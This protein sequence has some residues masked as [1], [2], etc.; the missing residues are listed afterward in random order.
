MILRC[1]GSD[2]FFI[3]KKA[4]QLV[5]Q[6]FLSRIF[7]HWKKS[8]FMKTTYLGHSCILME[9]MGKTILF[10]PFISGN[11]L[12]K[13]ID[14][15]SLNPDYILVSHAH[16][17]HVLDLERIAEKSKAK[18]VSNYEI[19]SYYNA[20]G[21]D[22]HPLN[23][24]GKASFDFG[25]VKYVNAVHSSVFPDGTYGGN[26]GGFVIW[27]EEACVY[28]AGD[29]ALTMDMKLIPMTCPAVD[30]AILPIGDNFTMDGEEALLAADFVQCDKIMACHYDTFGPIEVENKEELKKLFSDTGKTLLLPSVGESIKC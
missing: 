21:F 4:P 20:K 3:E 12:A 19:F 1:K 13:A 5:R 18:I 15:D 30:L 9:T 10:A 23:H 7:N 24:G 27:N 29:T 8:Y 6:R 22:G 17:D 16:M 25:T 28:F 11:P 14:I 26:P 2:F